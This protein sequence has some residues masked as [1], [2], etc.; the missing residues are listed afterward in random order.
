MA[1]AWHAEGNADMNKIAYVLA[2]LGMVGAL[3]AC[4]AGSIGSSAT[5]SGAS[6]APAPTGTEVI[7]A[8]ATNLDATSVTVKASGVF[9]DTGTL[10][11]PIRDQRTITFTFT[12]GNLVVL[13]AT[14]PTAGPL[15]VNKATC[16]FSQTVTGTY[17]VLAA[18]ST[19]RYAGATGHGTYT[20][21]PSGIAPKTS[22]GACNTSS[23]A[24]PA[25]ARLTVRLRGP[26]TL[27]T[28]N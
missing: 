3:T 19:G 9:T 24:T 20:L 12:R 28:G 5:G 8:S 22:G 1:S 11:L 21:N 14:G 15:H 17:R 13:N 18:N 7:R 26:L 16:A 4:T 10:K 23:N 6:S 2:A 27:N 25:K